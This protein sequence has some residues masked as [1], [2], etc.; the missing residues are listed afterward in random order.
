MNFIK[1]RLHNFLEQIAYSLKQLLN[2]SLVSNNPVL[3]T[4]AV[5][6][7]QVSEVNSELIIAQ[8]TGHLQ[9]LQA[10]VVQKMDIAI[11]PINLY[12][13]DNAIG[14]PYL[15]RILLYP[16]DIAIHLINLY[17]VD[18]AIGFPYLQRI[19]LYPVDIAI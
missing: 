14:F 2:A 8:N 15:Q 10:A 1:T 17:P 12:P 11:H 5:L 13:V 7:Y 16:V 18:N 3:V 19:L 9:D 6:V 4:A